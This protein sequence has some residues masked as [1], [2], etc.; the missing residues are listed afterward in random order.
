MSPGSLRRLSQATRTD[1]AH[2]ECGAHRGGA[3]YHLQSD[4]DFGSCGL[5]AGIRQRIADDGLPSPGG[6]GS[7]PPGG[8]PPRRPPPPPPPQR[9]PPP[10]HAPPPPPPSPPPP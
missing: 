10:P 1:I 8:G 7:P 5:R 6:C 4:D 2:R 9:K 3:R